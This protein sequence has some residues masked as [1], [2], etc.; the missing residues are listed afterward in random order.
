MAKVFVSPRS[1]AVE[2]W[3]L[4]SGNE[5]GDGCELRAEL[6]EWDYGEY[7][8]ITPTQARARRQAAGLDKG[9]QWDIWRDGC[10]GGESPADFQARLDTLIAEIK[11]LQGPL[12]KSTTGEPKDVVLISHGHTTRA[13]TKRWMGLEISQS[14]SLMMDPAAVGVLSYQHHNVEEPALCIGVGFP[15]GS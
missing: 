9:R 2:T 8:G 6:E 15:V 14:L 5:K 13:F 4:L 3:I 1:R 7:E 12:M 11:A 10:E